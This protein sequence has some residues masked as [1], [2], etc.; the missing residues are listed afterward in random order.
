[1]IDHQTRYDV[2]ATPPHCVWHL[3]Q[4]ALSR[5][6]VFGSGAKPVLVGG[7]DVGIDGWMLLVVCPQL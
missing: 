5:Q 2:E 3:C 4:S 1:M 7:K 6:F